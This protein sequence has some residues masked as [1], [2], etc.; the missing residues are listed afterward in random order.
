MLYKKLYC[1]ENFSNLSS[2][3]DES[4]NYHAKK[5]RQNGLRNYSRERERK[6]IINKEDGKLS[7][8]VKFSH[9]KAE[10]LSDS[11]D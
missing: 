10:Y 4:T 9:T 2:S 5:H 3:D 11:S 8:K 6:G 7:E 1:N